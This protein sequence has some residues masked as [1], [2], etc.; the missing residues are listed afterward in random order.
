MVALLVPADQFT[1]VELDELPEL[2]LTVLAY[3]IELVVSVAEVAPVLSSNANAAKLLKGTLEAVM[4]EA[5]APRL[6]QPTTSPVKTFSDFIIAS[7][8]G[9]LGSMHKH[10]I[11]G[12]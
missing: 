10:S 6:K 9:K 3:G 8:F 11:T 5:C 2:M 12:Q 1:V 7:Q 4:G